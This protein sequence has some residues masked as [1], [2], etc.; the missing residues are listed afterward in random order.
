MYYRLSIPS[1]I[2]QLHPLTRIGQSAGWI[3]FSIGHFCVSCRALPR[4]MAWPPFGS[5]TKF[6]AQPYFLMPG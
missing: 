6:T 5:I 3:R 4:T 1:W 2:Q